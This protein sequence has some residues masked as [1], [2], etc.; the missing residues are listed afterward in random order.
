MPK[1][2]LQDAELLLKLYELRREPELDKA[3]HWFLT[4][5]QP[6]E[7][8]D[9]KEQYLRGGEED[10][11]VRMVALYWDMVGALVNNDLLNEEL[12]FETNEEDIQ[13][14]GKVKPWIEGARR[15]FRP[16]Y[17]RNL[18][19]LAIRH[20]EWRQRNFSQLPYEKLRK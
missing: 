1:L 15:E 8:E 16:T 20:L 6:K 17:L 9:F 12:F 2:T 3:H 14:W 13:V 7:W 11:Y 19:I 5:Y 4:Q 18:E 10:R